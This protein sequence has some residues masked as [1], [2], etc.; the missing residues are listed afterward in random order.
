MTSYQVA[1]MTGSYQSN[2]ADGSSEE[3]LTSLF[4][5]PTYAEWIN[6]FRRADQDLH[7]ETVRRREA[8]LIGSFLN[9]WSGVY[10]TLAMDLRAEVEKSVRLVIVFLSRL[11]N[12]RLATVT[13]TDDFSVFFQSRHGQLH[14]YLEIHFGD[15]LP[16]E[17]L[18]NLY[19]NKV[20]IAA[21]EG[22]VEENLTHYLR[23]IR[24]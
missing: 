1:D 16:V 23:A 20:P 8:E 18:Y 15:D 13:V 24:A 9:Q 17:M 22:S 21:F 11:T 14:G 3:L 5:N 6:N 10:P 7:L 2:R 19:Q 4:N 12:L